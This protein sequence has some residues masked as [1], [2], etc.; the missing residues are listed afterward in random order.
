KVFDVWG[1]LDPERSAVS[2]DWI[3]P[4]RAALLNGIRIID[5]PLLTVRRHSQSKSNRYLNHDDDLVKDESSRANWI[6]Q[7]LYMLETLETGVAK[8]LLPASDERR[9]LNRALVKAIVRCA[10]DWRIHRN[11]LL[12]QGRRAQW[13]LIDDS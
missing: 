12:A 2:T 3:I 11:K 10:A 1:P 6:T 7:F 9:E 4:F 8:G 13:L 5:V